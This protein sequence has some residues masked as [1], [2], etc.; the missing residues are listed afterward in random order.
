MDKRH[1]PFIGVEM[2]VELTNFCRDGRCAFC[3]PMFRPTVMEAGP[4]VFLG[5]F[6]EHL[7]T[8]LD[9]G[10]TKVILTGGGEPTD[11]P[12]KLFGALRIIEQMTRRRGVELELLT[13][14]TNAVNLLRPMGSGSAETYLDRLAELGLRDINLSVHGLTYEQKKG[15]SGVAMADVDFDTLV[16]RIISKGIRVMTRTTLAKDY[17]ESAEQI[18]AFVRWATSLGVNI[19]YFSDLFRVPV[20]NKQT[21]PGSSTVLRWTDDHRIHFE[22]L[23]AALRTDGAFALVSEWTRHDNQGKTLEFKYCESGT[24]VMFGDL[25]IGDEST[26]RPTYAYVKPDGSLDTQ[27]NARN[28]KTRLYVPPEEVKAY[29][30]VF[31]P[32]REDL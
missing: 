30:Q 13:V 14:Y 16:P 26:E 24:R 7:E 29:L 22:N 20:R 10:G 9:G 23:L 4:E 32:G 17:I 15:I 3:S 25:V 21:T 27:N 1:A 19:A 8:Y 6:E 18:G 28:T 2:K 31:R 5:C 11:A 12:A